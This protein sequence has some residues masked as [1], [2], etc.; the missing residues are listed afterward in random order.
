MSLLIVGVVVAAAGV[1]GYVYRKVI[2]AKAEA[3]FNT[4]DA[5]VKANGATYEHKVVNEVEHIWTVIKGDVQG[6]GKSLVAAVNDLKSK[7]HV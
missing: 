5:W 2:I 7:L 3:E 6:I 1:A 4:A